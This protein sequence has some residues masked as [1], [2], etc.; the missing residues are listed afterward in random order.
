[1]RRAIEEGAVGQVSMKAARTGF[2]ESRDV[3]ALCRAHHVPVVVG[4]QYEGALG[5]LASIALGAAHPELAA[6][7]V[8]ASN[9]HDLASDL[10]A[11]PP[12][13]ED[14]HVRVPAG[15][16]LGA[17]LDEDALAAHRLEG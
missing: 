3:L 16:G 1:V 6:R 8:E 2:S 4:S 13:S 15:P 7:P 17:T 10:L 5:T 12:R 9:F 14:G 11:D